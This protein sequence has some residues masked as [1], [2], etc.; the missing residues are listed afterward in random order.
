MSTYDIN[1]CI[2]NIDQAQN[3][4]E[5]QS[6]AESFLSQQIFSHFA[7]TSY[8]VSITGKLKP[9]YEGQ[10]P[11]IPTVSRSLVAR[12][13]ENPSRLKTIATVLRRTMPYFSSPIYIGSAK[14]LRDRLRTHVRLIRK[15]RECLL[16]A[17]TPA[18]ETPS[19]RDPSEDRSDHS[20]AFEAVVQ[21]KLEPNDLLVSVLPMHLTPESTYDIEN[22]LNRINFPLCG[23]N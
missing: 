21:R 17:T 7:E 18:P 9:R 16:S 1:V 10:L 15:F 11:H 14:I 2:T 4:D 12:I 22:I 20:F 23:R 3:F 13:A 6:I 19:S 8:K 5:K